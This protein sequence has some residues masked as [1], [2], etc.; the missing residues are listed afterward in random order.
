MCIY[1]IDLFPATGALP[2]NIIE[3]F[4]RE[5]EIRY[6][7]RTRMNTTAAMAEHK[8]QK[9]AMNLL[10]KL[11]ENLQNDPDAKFLREAT[12]EADVTI[13]HLIKRS[14]DSDTQSKDY[15]FSRLSMDE[16]WAE[17]HRDV[18]NSLK[19]KAWKSR[20]IPADGMITFDFGVVHKD[21]SH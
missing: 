11:P 3:A 12:K 14:T 4:E 17:G 10:K 21:E 15:E 8:L 6:T 5:K 7:S 9:A 19:A 18:V 1:Q 2:R 16:H 13:L 20:K